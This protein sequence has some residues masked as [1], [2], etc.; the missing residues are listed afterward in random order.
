MIWSSLA[1]IT[2]QN[3]NF[4]ARGPA[5]ASLQFPSFKEPPDPLLPPL[6]SLPPPAESWSPAHLV[7]LSGHQVAPWFSLKLM[8]L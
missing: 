5:S 4:Q 2:E 3:F 7:F 8:T 6:Q 1:L